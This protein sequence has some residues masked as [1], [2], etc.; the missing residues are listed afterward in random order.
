MQTVLC[1]TRDSPQS[2]S[3]TEENIKS[4]YE[5]NASIYENQA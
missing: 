5:R 2:G 3:P 1:R 4:V